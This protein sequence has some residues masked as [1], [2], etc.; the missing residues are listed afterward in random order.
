MDLASII[1]TV[2][3]T[4][5][6]EM[7]SALSDLAVPKEITNLLSGVRNAIPAEIDFAG[8]AQFLLFFAAAALILGLM[9]RVFLGKRSSL[10][11][12]LSSAIGIL[13]IYALSVVVYTYKPWSLDA[14]LS[15]LP[16]VRFAGEYLVVIPFQGTT[17]PVLCSEILSL[18]ILAFLVNLLDAFIPQGRTAI[19]WYLLRFATVVLGMLLQL[20]ANWAFRTYLPDVL[21][22][23]APMILLIL[24]GVS[25]FM[26]L[27]NLVLSVVL[28]A[29]NPIFGAMYA[30]FFGSVIGKQLSKAIFTTGILCCVFFLLGFF[31]Y[32]VICI[33]AASLMTYIP[34]ALVLLV[35]WYIVGHIL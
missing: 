33:T 21:V 17:F 27:L 31:G 18:V 14:L 22:T 10:N 15:P 4:I 5:P 25:L 28:A 7:E 8:T 30:F 32:T 9:G 24:L 20:M 3:S 26:G 12:S 19:G 2:L 34:M 29:V 11:G 23:Y 16:F 1:P 35:L 6:T 13:A